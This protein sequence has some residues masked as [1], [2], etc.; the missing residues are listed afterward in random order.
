MATKQEPLEGDSE[1]GLAAALSRTVPGDRAHE[2]LD[3]AGV[4]YHHFQQPWR[5]GSTLLY[6]SL[7]V[8]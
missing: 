4:L 7:I 2:E 1:A 5:S 6:S 8:F 3:K